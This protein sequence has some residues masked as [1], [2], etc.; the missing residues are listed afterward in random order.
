MLCLV[1]GVESDRRRQDYIQL[2]EI[3]ETGVLMGKSRE[4]AASEK[5]TNHFR[6]LMH[7]YTH[8]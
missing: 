4:V 6:W 2:K 3:R 5:V 1:H 7:K 8:T